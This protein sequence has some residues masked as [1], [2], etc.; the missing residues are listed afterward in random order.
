MDDMRG[1]IVPKSDQLNSDDL[2]AGPIT[3]KITGVTIKAGE[4]PISIHYD[5]DNGKPYKACKSMCRVMVTAWGPDSKKYAGRSMTLY[6]D[7]A[8]KWA[9]MEVGGIRISHMSDID[10]T[11]TMALTATKGSRKPFTVRPLQK[12][13]PSQV[14]G[15]HNEEQHSPSAMSSPATVADPVYITAEEAFDLEVRCTELEIK[16]E[17]LA[18]SKIQRFSLLEMKRLAGANDWINKRAKAKAVV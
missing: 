7:P 8:V 11:L 2:I 5:G 13:A 1:V 4:Q 16:D 18:A 10:S 6:R 15:Q 14:P 9:G 12:S 3:V 17:F